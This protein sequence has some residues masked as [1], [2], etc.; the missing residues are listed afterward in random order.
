MVDHCIVGGLQCDARGYDQNH[1][2]AGA[3]LN[4]DYQLP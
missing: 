4:A 1:P 3:A 2:E